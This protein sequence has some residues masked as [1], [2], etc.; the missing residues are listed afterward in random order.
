MILHIAYYRVSTD[1]QGRSGLGLEAQ[2]AAVAS[3][4]A[5]VV[6]GELLAEFTEVESGKKADRPELAK[7]I[8][9]CKKH[10]ARLVIA[11]LDRLARNVYFVSGLMESGVDFVAVDMPYANRFT[12]HIMAAVA[13]HERE[14]TSKRTKEALA[15]VK[16]RGKRLGNPRPDPSLS[17]GRQTLA[18]S[19]AAYRDRVRPLIEPLY[20][21]GLSYREIARELNRRE[22]PTMRGGLWHGDVVKDALSA[23]EES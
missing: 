14:M 9:L 13:E 2:R 21:Q 19:L 3:Y 18:A 15:A 5:G 1:R 22:I 6:D 17:Q 7:A 16:Q 10:K 8:S 23:P 11:K 12:I 4:L 20:R